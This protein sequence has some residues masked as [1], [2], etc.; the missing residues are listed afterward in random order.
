MWLQR[1]CPHSE[2]RLKNTSANKWFTCDSS[3]TPEP[4]L[5]A[6]S[7]LVPHLGKVWV[8]IWQTITL[9]IEELG[10]ALQKTGGPAVVC[11]GLHVNAHLL[12]ILIIVDAFS[13]AQSHLHDTLGAGKMLLTVKLEPSWLIWDFYLSVSCAETAMKD[14]VPLSIAN[15][16]P[17]TSGNAKGLWTKTWNKLHTYLHVSCGHLNLSH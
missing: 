16:L 8:V 6:L 7:V 15:P 4:L 5:I 9:V 2:Q 17:V 13:P 10:P 12:Q 11:E 3:Q 14:S 1:S